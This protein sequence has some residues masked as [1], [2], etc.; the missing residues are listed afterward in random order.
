[1]WGDFTTKNVFFLVLYEFFFFAGIRSWLADKLHFILCYE[2][3]F[4]NPTVLKVH[5]AFC[6]IT[7][8]ATMPG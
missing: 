2:A 3:G 8:Y 5:P 4:Y 7:A 6:R 1:M